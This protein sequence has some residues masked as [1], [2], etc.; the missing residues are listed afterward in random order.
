MGAEGAILGPAEGKDMAT[1]ARARLHLALAATGIGLAAILVLPFVLYSIRFGIAGLGRD[2]SAESYLFL[3]GAAVSNAAMSLH[4]I[5]GG[6]L[7]ILAPLQLAG[8]LRARWPQLH[9]ALGRVTASL[10]VA[11]A[12]LG[13]V[14]LVLRGSIGGPWMDAGALGYG[15][16]MIVAA[17]MAVDRA[18][19]RDFARHREWAL[20]LIVLVIAAWIYRLHYALWYLATGGLW[21]EPD[22]TGAFDRVQVFA[23]YLPYLAVL[24][25]RFRAERRRTGPAVARGRRP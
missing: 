2:L 14:F 17:V 21:T 25:I 23:F 20:R 12:T 19:A 8:G 3:P 16:A 4:M 9:R 22:F 7:T 24:E 18:R 6:I 10:A 13:L 5:G 11:I 15:V 1:I